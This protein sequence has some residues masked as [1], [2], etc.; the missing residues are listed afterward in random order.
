M[1]WWQNRVMADRFDEQVP[2]PAQQLDQLQRDDSLI[3]RGMADPLDEGYVPPD[4]WSV[5]EGFGNTAAEQREGE[6]LD[7]RLSQEEP[8]DMERP[9]GNWNPSGEPR[10]VG[11]RRAGRLVNANGGYDGP[12]DEPESL[13]GEVGLAGGA[14]SAEE[15]AMHVID[16]NAPDD[17]DADDDLEVAESMS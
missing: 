10:Q 1:R 14:A 9:G 8:E 15:A 2:E 13:G 7:M 17:P 3:N 6:T 4:H 12:D 11:A 5:A 16:L